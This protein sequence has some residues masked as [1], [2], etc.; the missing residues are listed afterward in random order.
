MYL[1]LKQGGKIFSGDT[2]D[3]LGCRI[4]NVGF[5]EIVSNFFCGRF[6]ESD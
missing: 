2:V 3:V 4:I 6:G 5:F 1:T